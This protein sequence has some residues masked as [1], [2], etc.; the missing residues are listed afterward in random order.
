[1]CF[2]TDKKA[3]KFTELETDE[4]KMKVHEFKQPT[5]IKPLCFNLLGVPYPYRFE[6]MHS[7]NK[8]VEL[9][10]IAIVCLLF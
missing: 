8:Y 10:A 7:V 4:I 3:R 2:P 9:H 6:K 5:L 1:M